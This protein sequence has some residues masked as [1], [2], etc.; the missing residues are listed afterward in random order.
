MKIDGKDY[1]R[2]SEVLQ[3]VKS[4][5]GR[6][7]RLLSAYDEAY[8][9]K[10]FEAV[11]LRD[12]LPSAQGGRRDELIEVTPGFTLWRSRAVAVVNDEGPHSEL[13]ASV[14]ELTSGAVRFEQLCKARRAGGHAARTTGRSPR[15]RKSK[16]EPSA[17]EV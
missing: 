15:S 4:D 13:A 10:V 7:K 11:Y 8:R 14:D 6:V 9:S 3:P 1:V 2:L 5:A 17:P 12:A 16:G